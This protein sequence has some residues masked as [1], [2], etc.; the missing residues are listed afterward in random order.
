MTNED[1]IRRTLARYCQ[2]FNS[3]Q[4]DELGTIF[5]EDASVTSRR[6]TFKGRAAVIRDLKGAMTNDYRGT[7]FATNFVITVDGEAATAVSDFL[8]VQGKEI[9]E[10]GTYLDALAKSGDSWLLVRKEIRLK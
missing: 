10:V 9:L 7:L 6:G 3:K 4:W 1:G 2:L 5:S 8:A